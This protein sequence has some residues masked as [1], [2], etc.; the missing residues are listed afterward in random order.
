METSL[1]EKQKTAANSKEQLISAKVIA[2]YGDPGLDE[3]YQF[4]ILS[5]YVIV[6]IESVDR[7]PVQDKWGKMIAVVQR[8][9]ELWIDAVGSVT[10][11]SSQQR[12]DNLGNTNT[13]P[14]ANYSVNA[15]PRINNP[16]QMGEVIYLRKLPTP[17]NITNTNQSSIFK[18]KFTTMTNFSYNNWHNQGSTLAYISNG[19]HQNDLRAKTVQLLPNTG[20]DTY[21]APQLNKYQYEA[22]SLNNNITSPNTQAGL[23][24]IFLGQWR[25][26]GQVYNAN[27]GYIFNNSNTLVINTIEFEDANKGQ[28][29]RVGSNS[30]IP[31]IVCS[32]DQFLTPKSRSSGTINFSPTI[33]PISQ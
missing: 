31:L 33:V 4:D 16:Y 20:G 21:Y 3:D 24:Q 14:C 29:M 27:G 18:S 32:P 19:N 12:Q 17:L 15:I 23:A 8:P 2:N 26:Y 11:Q 13:G 30:C 22:F 1:T 28:K 10:T 9:S 6:A 25:G 5:K 7:V